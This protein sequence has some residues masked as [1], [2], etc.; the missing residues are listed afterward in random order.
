MVHHCGLT[1][2]FSLLTP[3]L[4]VLQCYSHP[5]AQT[6][7]D[8]LP[9]LESPGLAGSLE[10]QLLDMVRWGALGPELC[11]MQV[12]RNGAGPRFNLFCCHR[13]RHWRPVVKLQKRR[14]SSGSSRRLRRGGG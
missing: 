6:D 12:A 4:M 14:M 5:L 10:L 2:T 1:T 13:L 8:L 3:Q 9:S 7:L 11:S